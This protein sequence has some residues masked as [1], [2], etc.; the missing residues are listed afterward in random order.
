M[1]GDQSA[2]ERAI[3][4][5]S[6]DRNTTL[7]ERLANVFKKSVVKETT[8]RTETTQPIAEVELPEETKTET[9]DLTDAY[10]TLDKV[11]SNVIDP[12]IGM[13]D[14]TPYDFLKK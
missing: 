13:D 1:V 6:S 9:P 5:K 3:Q 4:D 2:F 7:V 11:M 12:M 10:L 14:V 8:A